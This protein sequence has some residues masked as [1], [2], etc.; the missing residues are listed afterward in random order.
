M[1]APTTF[2]LTEAGFQ[3][4]VIELARLCSWRIYHTR[5][6]KGSNHGWPD[7]VLCRSPEVLFAELKTEKGTLTV[8]QRHW[9][10]A[11]TASGLE[12]HL[13]RP[14]HWDDIEARLTRA[15]ARKAAA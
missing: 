6:S 3:S 13:W 5:N 8:E 1:T 10:E 7:I 15:R 11:L 2:S 9:L 14:S 4:A 12:V